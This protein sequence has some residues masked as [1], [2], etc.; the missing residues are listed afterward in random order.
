MKRKSLKVEELATGLYQMS[1]MPEHLDELAKPLK[2][3]AD[4]KILVDEETLDFNITA[5]YILAID[6][7]AFLSFGETK[8]KNKIFNKFN[9]IVKETFSE[10]LYQLLNAKVLRF[11]DALKDKTASE[12][13][14]KLSLYFSQCITILLKFHFSKLKL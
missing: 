10:D 4:S 3:R 5:L 14:L 8:V 6:Y 1:L 13:F 11:S 12:P 9:E 2:T 7:S